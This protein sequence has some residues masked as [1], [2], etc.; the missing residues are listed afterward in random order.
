[1]RDLRNEGAGLKEAVSAERPAPVTLEDL[2]EQFAGP[3]EAEPAE[4]PAPVTLE[5]L[6]AWGDKHVARVAE[7]ERGPR[8]TR[9]QSISEGSR[10]RG[11]GGSGGRAH[12][13]GTGKHCG[14]GCG[15]DR[16]GRDQDREGTR[17]DAQR[18]Q[19]GGPS[20]HPTVEVIRTRGRAEVRLANGSCG[21]DRFG[22]RHADREPHPHPLPMAVD[23]LSRRRSAS[24]PLPR[25]GAA[26][27][28][29]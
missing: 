16:G 6:E 5:A 12:R 3:R 11:E 17:D 7:A 8:T 14:P 15:R 27:S 20:G 21:L 1:M 26:L 23:R 13:W 22:L 28:G 19:A 29:A 25:T 2:R 10:K 4:G 24:L 9:R 18:Q